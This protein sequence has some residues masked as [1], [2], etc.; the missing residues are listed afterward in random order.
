MISRTISSHTS[1]LQD[2]KNAREKEIKQ[3]EKEKVENYILSLFV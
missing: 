3:E 2:V 1:F